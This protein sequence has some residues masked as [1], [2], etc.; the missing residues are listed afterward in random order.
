MDIKTNNPNMYDNLESNILTNNQNKKK[1]YIKQLCFVG[2]GGGLGLA[3]K[4]NLLSLC[5]HTSI[6]VE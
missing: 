5:A 1:I 3:R 6:Y 4:H 2:G